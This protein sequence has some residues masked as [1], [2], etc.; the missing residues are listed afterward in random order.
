MK[1]RI[2][3]LLAG[4]LI[5]WPFAATAQEHYPAR[6]VRV[7]VPYLAGG[8][9]DIFGRAVAQ[10]L[11]EALKQPF[12]VEN[13]G[14]ANGGIGS[15]LVAKSAP[16]GYTLL[17]TASGPIT[18]NPVLYAKVL[19]ITVQLANYSMRMDDKNG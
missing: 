7:I 5:Q 2:A 6:P 16:D 17:A 12:I 14:G 18:V 10:K 11:S 9:A 3:A 13:R 1:L 15:D 8:A 19:I 4:I